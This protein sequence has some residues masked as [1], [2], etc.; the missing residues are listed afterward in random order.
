MQ[1]GKGHIRWYSTD[2]SV[3]TRKH[4]GTIHRERRSMDVNRSSSGDGEPHL[5]CDPSIIL[6]VTGVFDYH[7]DAFSAYEDF[8]EHYELVRFAVEQAQRSS[9]CW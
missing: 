6:A 8:G 4:F 1:R 3:P 2:G 9:E 5:H 7:V